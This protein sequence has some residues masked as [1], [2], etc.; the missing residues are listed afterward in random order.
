MDTVP[1]FFPETHILSPI[2]KW[3]GGKEQELKYILP[4]LPVSIK[5]YF[6][7][8]IGGGAVCMALQSRP[9]KIFINDKSSELINLYRMLA[10]SN[11]AFFMALDEITYNWNL[12][13][14]VTYNNKDYFLRLIFDN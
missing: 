9:K 4:N 12:L 10:E 3:P 11:K 2:I 1:C 5:N 13:E 7:P 14:K 6:E 8:F